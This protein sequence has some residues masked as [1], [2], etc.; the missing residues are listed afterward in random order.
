VL[1]ELRGRQE[2]EADPRFVDV[3]IPPMRRAETDT[4]RALAEL[5]SEVEPRSLERALSYYESGLQS[6]LNQVAAI[7]AVLTKLERGES[8]DGKTG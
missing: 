4:V 5:Y 3:A 2:A 6:A 8:N 7:R 1:A